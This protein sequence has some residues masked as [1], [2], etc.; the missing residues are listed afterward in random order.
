MAIHYFLDALDDHD[1]EL[2]ITESEPKYLN[3]AYTRA[4]RLKMIGKKGTEKIVSRR[5][6][7]QASETH[8]GGGD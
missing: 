5:R 2:K 7:G 4:L 8:A 6:T 1:F 3:E